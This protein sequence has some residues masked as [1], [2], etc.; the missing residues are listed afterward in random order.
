M[1]P[2]ALLLV[3]C[4]LWSWASTPITAEAY[5]VTN[6]NGE[7]LLEHNPDRERPIASITKLFVA[8]QAVKLDQDELLTVTK[9]DYHTGRM[10]S[11]PLRVGH[12]YKRRQ[13]IELALISSD[14]VAALTLARTAP[15]D[16]RYATL[17]EGSGLDPANRSTARQ[18]AE[19]AR[20]LYLTEVGPRSIELTAEIGARHSTNP[21]LEK[22]GWYFLLSKTGFINSSGGCLT[23]VLRVKSELLTVVILG[24]ANTRQR[25]ADLIELRRRLGDTDFYV[26]VKVVKPAAKK[27]RH[28]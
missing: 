26:P 28:K 9:G 4:P 25:W 20:E 23:V 24:A 6:L 16:T 18:L 5:I 12:S 21:L 2:L 17:V 10:R 15:P 3:L 7:V 27:R 13:L 22:D 14:N 19:A 11:T 8:E 1:K